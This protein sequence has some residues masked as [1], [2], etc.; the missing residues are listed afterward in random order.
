MIKKED[1][2]KAVV[3]LKLNGVEPPYKMLV[4]L[5]YENPYGMW[6][7]GIEILTGY[8]VKEMWKKYKKRLKKYHKNA[9]KAAEE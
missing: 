2:E 1:I 3:K 5:P 9:G 7:W 6:R 4:Q 8:S